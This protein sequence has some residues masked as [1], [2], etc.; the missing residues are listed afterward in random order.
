LSNRVKLILA[1]LFIVMVLTTVVATSA[2]A[3][4]PGSSD[5]DTTA[6]AYCGQ[7][8]CNSATGGVCQSTCQGNSGTQGCGGPCAGRR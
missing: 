3:A 7:Q 2:F 6:P 1:A 4:A 5:S 8:S